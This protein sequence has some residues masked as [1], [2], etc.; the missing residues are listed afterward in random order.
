MG[1]KVGPKVNRLISRNLQ[2]ANLKTGIMLQLSLQ[3]HITFNFQWITYEWEE[4]K[5]LES[6]CQSIW[7]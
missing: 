1:Q 5:Y 2:N 4:Y 6:S 7:H 3:G